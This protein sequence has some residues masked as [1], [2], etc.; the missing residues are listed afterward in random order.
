MENLISNR[1]GTTVEWFLFSVE[2]KVFYNILLTVLS[3][4]DPN[5][6]YCLDEKV[7]CKNAKMEVPHSNTAVFTAYSP[8]LFPV[9]LGLEQSVFPL[10]AVIMNHVLSWIEV[11]HN[12]RKR[13]QN[14]YTF[15]L[16]FPPMPC[17]LGSLMSENTFLHITRLRTVP[18]NKTKHNPIVLLSVFLCY[19]DVYC[20]L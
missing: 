14:I 18:F 2:Y 12:F 1:I 20:L 8:I 19:I 7:K 4:I 16:L 3:S 17:L 5:F 10:S 13:W 15:H 6:W 11:K 9:L